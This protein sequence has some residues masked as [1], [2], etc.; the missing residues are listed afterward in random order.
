LAIAQ[1]EKQY[2]QIYPERKILF[3]HQGTGITSK[4]PISVSVYLSEPGSGIQFII[5]DLKS[6]NG[7]PAIV[8][9]LAPYVV[10]T[11]RN[12]VLGKGSARLCLVEHFLAAAAFC[13][14]FD[15]DVV[16]D[17]PELPLGDGS[18]AFWI[19]LFSQSGCAPQLPEKKYLLKEPV[20]A[21]KADRQLIALPAAVFSITYLMDWQHPAIGKRWCSWTSDQSPFDLARARTFGW[22]KDHDLLGLTDEVVSLTSDGFSQPLHFEDEP[23]RHKLLD[24][25]GDL[26]LSGINPLAIQAQ[27]ISIKGGHAMDVELVKQLKD[28]LLPA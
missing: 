9:A 14:V 25:L 3:A 21:T 8:P 27:F 23:V 26:T 15:M 6:D 5:P 13:N 10:N 19:E 2:Q 20:I 4:Q 18:A 17:G 1:L 11:L 22:Q 24:F 16:V 12:V 28:K 7:R